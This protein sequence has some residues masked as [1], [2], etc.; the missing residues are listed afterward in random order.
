MCRR[1]ASWATRGTAWPASLGAMPRGRRS[2]VGLD[3]APSGA[4]HAEPLA[5]ATTDG[6]SGPSARRCRR[7]VVVG[8]Q[9]GLNYWM[10]GL[11]ILAPRRSLYPIGSATLG[12]GV[13]RDPRGRVLTARSSP[14]SATG[15]ALHRRGAG[16]C[17]KYR[18]PVVYVVMNIRTTG[19]PLSQAQLYGRTGEHALAGPDV[20]AL[21]RAFGVKRIRPPAPRRSVGPR[22]GPRPLRPADR[23][24]ARHRAAVGALTRSPGLAPVGISHLRDTLR[25]R[26]G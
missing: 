4:G 12:Y 24:A 15:T 19:R 10:G 13:R 17:R 14:S 21:A 23:G 1:S 8:D 9:T 5:T 16:H 3:R 7:M 6:C 25:G 18:L 2:P 20:L 22:R 26:P 11:P